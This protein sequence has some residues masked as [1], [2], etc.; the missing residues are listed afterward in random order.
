MTWELFAP[1][2]TANLGPGFDV[3]GAALD[4]EASFLVE[5]GPG[6]FA[7]PEGVEPPIGPNLFLD[8]FK[9]AFA[10]RGQQ[11]PEVSVQA[12][13]LLP[14]R[15]GLGSS[16]SAICA[17]LRAA[18]L[19][20]SSPL[21]PREALRI[22]TALEGHPDNVAACL[23]GGVTIASGMAD[24][25]LR[26]LPAPPLRAVALYPGGSTSTPWSRAA[27]PPL[28]PRG[29]AVH[30]IGRTALLVYAMLEGDYALLRDAT[31]DR[32]HEAERI[33]DCAWCAA[34]R[35]AAYDAGAYAMPVSG[36]GPTMLAIT[37]P[38]RADTVYSAL[39]P[40]A[41]QLPGGMIWNLG[42]TEQA[43]RARALE[44]R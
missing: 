9:A 42:F 20:L 14:L 40:F 28:V 21:A 8:A 30:N 32:L 13:R 3:L 7:W 43:A 27:L 6:G 2:T 26:R 25:L 36:S 38:E 29:S 17:G 23:F 4:L 24:P 44:P 39:L 18:D 31:E 10:A 41:R 37:S 15:A 16:A 35:A 34:A 12:T 1:A 33:G 22:A 11:A 5:A 19:F